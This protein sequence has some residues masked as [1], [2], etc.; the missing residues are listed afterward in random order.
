MNTKQKSLTI[1]KLIP[2]ILRDRGRGFAM[3]RWIGRVPRGSRFFRDGIERVG[4]SCGTVACIGGSIQL[5]THSRAG[6]TTDADER[7]V[8]RTLGLTHRQVET[9]CYGWEQSV[10]GAPPWPERFR[11]RY[12][13]ARTPLGKARVACALLR[14]VVRTNGS[15][16]D[17]RKRVQG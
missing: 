1:R 16:L 2:F 9:L 8:Q 14:E 6:L 11:R 13:R 12:A 4:P 10:G 5:L 7:L 17:S 3:Q 15:C